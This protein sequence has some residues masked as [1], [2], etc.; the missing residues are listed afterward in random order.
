MDITTR[1]AIARQLACLAGEFQDLD[2]LLQAGIDLDRQAI[3]ERIHD[4]LRR[5]GTKIELLADRPEPF[6]PQG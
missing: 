5:Y 1:L 3:I 2:D 6:K 4:I